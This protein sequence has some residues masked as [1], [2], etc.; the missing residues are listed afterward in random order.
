MRWQVAALEE[1]EAWYE[2]IAVTLLVGR[3]HRLAKYRQQGYDLTIP[4][5]PHRFAICLQHARSAGVATPLGTAHA[6]TCTAANTS[7]RVT[8]PT[9]LHNFTLIHQH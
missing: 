9:L 3:E 6:I 4:A 1:Q 7:S 8:T 5:S 2:W